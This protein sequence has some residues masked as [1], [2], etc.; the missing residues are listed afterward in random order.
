MKDAQVFP[1]GMEFFDVYWTLEDLLDSEKATYQAETARRAQE[2][3]RK[4]PSVLNLLIECPSCKCS[5]R[6]HEYGGHILDAICPCCNHHFRPT[7]AELI[8]S[9][10]ITNI[11]A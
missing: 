7:S 4:F 11:G 3:A 8:R 2:F 10:Y 1:K 6:C 9:L 5:S